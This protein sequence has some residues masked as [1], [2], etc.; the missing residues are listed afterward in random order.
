MRCSSFAAH[1]AKR[2][3]NMLGRTLVIVLI[4]TLA[5][6]PGF[7]QGP[8]GQISG[9]VTD[10]TRAV[11]PGVGVTAIQTETGL[12]RTV[13]TNEAGA[14]TLSSLPVGPYKLEAALPGFRT[15]LQ[16]GLVLQVNASL[17]MDA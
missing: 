1:D 14:Y 6:A 7:S 13:V 3:G 15:F 16:T 11:L 9:R 12:V 5:S 17:V 8:T 4:A 2:G 10:A